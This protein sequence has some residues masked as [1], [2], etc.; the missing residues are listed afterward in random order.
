MPEKIIKSVHTIVIETE[1]PYPEAYPHLTLDAAIE[2]QRHL[3][4]ESM[5]DCMMVG[6]TEIKTEVTV[7]P[8]PEDQETTRGGD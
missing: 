7:Q 8:A 6:K 2:F 3:D 4:L 1:I 5:I